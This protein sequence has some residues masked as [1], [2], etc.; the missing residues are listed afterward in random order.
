MTFFKIWFGDK[1]IKMTNYF[2]GA[3]ESSMILYKGPL[4]NIIEEDIKQEDE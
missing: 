1:Y 2:K 4:Y 3:C